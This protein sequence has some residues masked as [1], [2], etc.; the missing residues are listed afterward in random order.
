M[1]R[2]PCWRPAGLYLAAVPLRDR[3]HPEDFVGRFAG[4]SRHVADFLS[5]DV[6]ARQPDAVIGFLLYTCVLEE[7]TASLC[8]ALT[9]TS[10]ADAGRRW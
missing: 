2:R 10:R 6:L 8:A 7:L 5:E 9:G 3:P 1:A 4:T